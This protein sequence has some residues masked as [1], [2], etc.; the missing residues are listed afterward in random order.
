MPGP[1]S[2]FDFYI[3]VTVTFKT[4][5]GYGNIRNNFDNLGRNVKRWPT[6]DFDLT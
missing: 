2:N 4:V 6:F 1:Q 3:D 5:G